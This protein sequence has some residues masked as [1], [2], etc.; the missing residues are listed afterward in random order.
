MCY[1][2]VSYNIPLRNNMFGT[3]IW[4]A[5][6]MPEISMSI[7]LSYISFDFGLKVPQEF[8]SD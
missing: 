2:Q 7:Y 8:I 1:T 5:N 6:I 3:S 4:H